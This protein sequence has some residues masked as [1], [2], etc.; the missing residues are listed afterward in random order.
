MKTAYDKAIEQVQNTI[1]IEPW[2]KEVIEEIL[3]KQIPQKWVYDRPNH[4]SCPACG[5][6]MGLAARFFYNY[7]YNCGQRTYMDETEGKT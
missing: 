6:M 5:T 4:W 7:C 3:R 1:Y 2:V